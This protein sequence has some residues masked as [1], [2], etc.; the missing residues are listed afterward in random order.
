MAKLKLAGQTIGLGFNLRH[1]STLAPC[2]T[3]L[4]EK[5][6][7]SKWKNQHKTTFR[8]SPASILTPQTNMTTY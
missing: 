5:L 4:R 1:G 3:F 2:T 8:F 6:P 7:K